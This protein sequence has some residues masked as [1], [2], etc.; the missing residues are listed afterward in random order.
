MKVTAMHKLPDPGLQKQLEMQRARLLET[1]V[2]YVLDGQD[3]TPQ[4]RLRTAS[5]LSGIPINLIEVEL[6]K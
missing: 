2:R 3:G 1:A 4:D 5:S 6:N